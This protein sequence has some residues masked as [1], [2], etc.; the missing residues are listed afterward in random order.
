MV[1]FNDR[2]YFSKEFKKLFEKNP[3]EYM[4]SSQEEES[5]NPNEE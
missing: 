5:D 3:S 4:N 1:G 2:K